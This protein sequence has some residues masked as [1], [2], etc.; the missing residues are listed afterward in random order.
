MAK[1]RQKCPR[2]RDVRPRSK[3][4]LRRCFWSPSGQRAIACDRTAKLWNF[5]RSFSARSSHQSSTSRV[6]TLPRCFLST[7]GVENLE[8]SAFSGQR[9]I[10]FDR[11]AK[12]SVEKCLSSTPLLV[13]VRGRELGLLVG[14]RR[15]E[16]GFLVGTAS[17]CQTLQ[18]FSLLFS[19][20]LVGGKPPVGGKRREEPGVEL[21][22]VLVLASC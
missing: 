15:R 6:A 4:C 1:K 12:L 8:S 5:S 7:S 9:A 21:R 22:E 17:C 19:K 16:L 20:I 14:V 10:A 13:D 11:T 18:L 2:C 3:R